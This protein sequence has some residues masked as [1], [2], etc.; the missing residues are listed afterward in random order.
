MSYLSGVP[1][2]NIVLSGLSFVGAHFIIFMYIRFEQ[3]RSFAFKL[4][5]YLAISDALLA[6][7]RMLSI[8]QY[9]KGETFASQA[10]HPGTICYLQGLIENYAQLASIFWVDVIAGTL[11]ATVVK[12]IPDVKNKLP[13]Y[14]AFGYCTP[15]LFTLV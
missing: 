3:L 9:T 12:G 13:H 1:L 6:A 14:I 4:V 7:G 11:Y 2:L 5:L 10:E 15:L 8:F